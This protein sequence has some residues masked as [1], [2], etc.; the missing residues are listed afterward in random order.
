M[1]PI[2]PR[3]TSHLGMESQKHETDESSLIA[4]FGPR[5]QACRPGHAE[6]TV[7][8]NALAAGSTC[9][10]S[11][12][13]MSSGHLKSLRQRRSGNPELAVK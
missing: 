4:T 2:P 9:M 8:V 11:G 13:G 10:R 6:R 12:L 3:R 5:P 1:A 7:G